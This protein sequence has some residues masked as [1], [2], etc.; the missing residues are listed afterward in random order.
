[1]QGERIT[2]NVSA[3]ET[4]TGVKSTSRL[5][6]TQF[7]NAN[8]RDCTQTQ[9]HP[10]TRILLFR[11]N[12]I[13][14]RWRKCRL[15]FISSALSGCLL[16]LSL[17]AAFTSAAAVF[18]AAAILLSFALL[19]LYCCFYSC[20]QFTRANI[21]MKILTPIHTYLDI[22]TTTAH[23]HASARGWWFIYIYACVCAFVWTVVFIHQPLRFP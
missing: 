3:E 14:L 5:A 21:K 13:L 8:Q 18:V 17:N 23:T 1:M 22:C 7:Y 10:R 16:K 12:V 6:L 4:P 20:W 9:R 15:H 2:E 19:S 11:S